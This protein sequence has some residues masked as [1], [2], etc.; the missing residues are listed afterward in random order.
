MIDSNLDDPNDLANEL[1]IPQP[2]FS[3]PISR[4]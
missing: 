4:C 1:D 3:I 2:T